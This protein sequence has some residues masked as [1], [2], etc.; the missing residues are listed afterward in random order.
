[1][2]KKYFIKKISN[3]AIVGGMGAV[4]MT[5]FTG[6]E[7]KSTN[8]Q[9]N[10]TIT[11]AS[12]KQGAFVIVEKTQQGGYQIVDEYPSSKTTIVL[13]DGQNERILSKAEVDQLVAQ[14]ARKI[15]NGTS[16]LTNP[17]QD[18]ISGGG[19][20]LG[21]TLLASA[22]GAMIGA[23][24]GNKLFN[25]SNYQS[26]RRTNYKSPSTYSKSVNSFNKAKTASSNKSSSSKKS[27]FFGGSKSSSSRS[28]FFGG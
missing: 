4:L 28:S 6:C 2:K 11:N 10:D 23:Y 26:Q 7:D 18:S 1:M 3:F 13:R 8:T 20:S 24:I 15:D 27:G 16:N 17:N 14:E 5:S 21:E 25:N 12:Q 22:A 19:M 9:N